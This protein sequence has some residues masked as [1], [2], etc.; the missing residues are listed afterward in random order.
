M[1]VRRVRGVVLRLVRRRGLAVVVGAA[2]AA[3]AAW[4]ELSGRFESWWVDGLTLVVGATGVALLWAG[5]TGARPDWI[6]N[7]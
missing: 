7:G 5:L 2:L 1:P 6:E 3:P 4:L